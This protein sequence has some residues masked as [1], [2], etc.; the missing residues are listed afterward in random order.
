M[1]S[2]IITTAISST[3]YSIIARIQI[4]NRI[5]VGVSD[6]CSREMADH[7]NCHYNG[8]LKQKT[9]KNSNNSV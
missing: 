2:K 4:T 6:S 9:E 7:N 3:D 5:T 1:F 8:V